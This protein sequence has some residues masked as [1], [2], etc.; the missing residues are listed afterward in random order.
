MWDGSIMKDKTLLVRAEQGFGDVFQFIRYLPLIRSRVGRLIFGCHLPS[1]LSLLQNCPDIDEIVETSS[2]NTWLG[3]INYQIPILS[4]PKTFGTT[5]NNIP[6]G[7]PYLNADP[8]LQIGWEE[9]IKKDKRLR[10]GIV[11]AGNPTHPSDYKRSSSLS[12]F[13][14]LFRIKGTAWFSLQKELSPTD[15]KALTKE[16]ITN[17]ANE[18]RDFSDTAAAIANLDLIIAVDT[19]IVH[20]AGAM[21]KPVWTLLPFMA[22][23]RW[24]LKREDSPWYQTMK[25]FRQ[26][27]INYWKGVFTQV[28]EALLLQ[29]NQ[30]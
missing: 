30:K 16:N 21:G 24:L 23:W 8:V 13:K 2:P 18:F 29:I 19:S 25:L 27:K 3:K 4:L 22:E 17:L 10:I 6:T 12:C 28:K 26:T 1:L 20:L 11:W 5:L 9:K 15:L 7:I 14:P